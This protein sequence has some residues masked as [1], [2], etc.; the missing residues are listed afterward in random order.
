MVCARLMYN[1]TTIAAT[2]LRIELN[3]TELSP[4]RL[5][6]KHITVFLQTHPDDVDERPLCVAG[7]E[8]SPNLQHSQAKVRRILKVC[9][10]SRWIEIDDCIGF[11]DDGS[12]PVH[13]LLFTV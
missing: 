1:S 11:V 9:G 7:E 6:C 13:D 10:P 12:D 4:L 5:V 3:A 8:T 2:I